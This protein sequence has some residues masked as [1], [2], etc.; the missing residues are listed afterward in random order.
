MLF[1]GLDVAGNGRIRRNEFPYIGKV[2]RLL[3]RPARSRQQLR[4]M[5][6]LD[7]S[8]WVKCQSN[9]VEDVLVGLGFSTSETE[10]EAAE[11][12]TR[13]QELGFDGD[14]PQVVEL[15][16]QENSALV[17]AQSLQA[18]LSS[19]ALYAPGSP[20]GS[21]NQS[22]RVTRRSPRS[23][24]TPTPKTLSKQWDSSMDKTATQNTHRCQGSRVF[25]TPL[26]RNEEHSLWSTAPSVTSTPE[27][28][29]LERPGW[30]PT[31]FVHVATHPHSR[32]GFDEPFPKPVRDEMR[33]KV[34]RNKGQLSE[35]A[36]GARG[37]GSI[38]KC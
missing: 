25:F 10:L 6:I 35:Q 38:L 4:S 19:E 5:A 9:G 17:S 15:A 12:A 1:R 29:T 16:K 37:G 31:P 30:N 34:Q 36:T 18:L 28:P 7:F 13:L 11:L 20:S 23:P 32:R 3:Q 22:T 26:P 24:G 33:A 14:V 8:S 21:S 27:K 2:S